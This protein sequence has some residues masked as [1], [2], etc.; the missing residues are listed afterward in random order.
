MTNLFNFAQANELAK[1]FTAHA[2]KI[3]AVQQNWFQSQADAAKAQFEAA[4]SNKDLAATAQ[5]IQNNLQPVA[6]SLVKHAQELFNLTLTAQKELAAKV[7]EGYQTA[8]SEANTA[9]EAGIKQLPN[10]GEPF[11]TMAKQASQAL[12][13]ITEQVASQ[14]KTAQAGYEAQIAK[15]FDT[16][17]GQVSPA[18][19]AKAKK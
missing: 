7:Q 8:A 12:N 1:T 19:V 10:Q 16:A 4:S 14:F 5:S 15:L 17:L 18:V 13:G 9:V 6:Q 3:A 11:V 2:T